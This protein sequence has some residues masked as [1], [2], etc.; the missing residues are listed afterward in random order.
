MNL[1]LKYKN[2]IMYKNSGKNIEAKIRIEHGNDMR[3]HITMLVI[4][5][6]GS[7]FKYDFTVKDVTARTTDV[8]KAL[9]NSLLHKSLLKITPMRFIFLEFVE[10]NSVSDP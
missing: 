5:D 10:F 7:P 6:P 2:K 3:F 1:N 9:I 4:F 8:E